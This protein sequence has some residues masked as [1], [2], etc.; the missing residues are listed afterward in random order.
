M[1]S[2]KRKGA[3]L[4]QVFPPA[5]DTA[6]RFCF[7]GAVLLVLGLLLGGSDYSRSSYANQVGWVQSQPVPFSHGHH[8]GDDGIDCRYCHTSVEEG[9]HAGLPP[10]HTCMTCHSQIWTGAEVLAPVRDSAAT[11]EPIRWRRVSQLPDYVYFNHSIHVDRGVACVECHGRVDEMPL[12][13]RAKPFQMQF[14]LECHRDP[15]SRLRPRELVTRM[16][17]L[18]WSEK[19]KRQYGLRVMAR[20]DIDP[21]ML[22]NCGVCHR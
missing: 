15:A 19:E 18:G 8:V 6:L 11:G 14:C 9:P 5:A 22:D 10:T 2:D 16:E 17:P 1:C 7:A 12:M 3:A 13:Q 20:H 21:E 4:A